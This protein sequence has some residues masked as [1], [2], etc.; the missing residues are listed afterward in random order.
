M[1]ACFPRW[2]KLKTAA[3]YSGI[4]RDRLKALA[5]AGHIK[6]FQDPAL[7]SMKLL[8]FDESNQSLATLGDALGIAD[9]EV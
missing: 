4:G 9:K 5:D 2:M 8:I 7:N 6:G 3:F 1:T